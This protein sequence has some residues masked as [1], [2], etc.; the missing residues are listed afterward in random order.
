LGR[1][2][3][4]DPLRLSLLI[5]S[6]AGACIVLAFPTSTLIAQDLTWNREIIFSFYVT[7]CIMGSI[8][9]LFPSACRKA[10]DPEDSVR[11]PHVTLTH[12]PK[13]ERFSGHELHLGERS[14]CAGCTGLLTGALISIPLIAAYSTGVTPAQRAWIPTE[15]GVAATLL[16]LF[17]PLSNSRNS[18]LRFAMGASFIVGMTFILI[19]LDSQLR[20]IDVDLFILLMTL[21]WVLTRISLSQFVHKR[22]CESCL[23][24][25]VQQKRDRPEVA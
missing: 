8:A 22:I 11:M 15:L 23:R 7:L 25:C 20:S 14:F 5:L 17:M 3:L 9:A 16:G 24:R 10:R 19:G 6:L 21:F 12:H 18:L 2:F 13:C 4:P 1:L